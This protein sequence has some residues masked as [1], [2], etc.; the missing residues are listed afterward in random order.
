MG[1]GLRRAT[2]ATLKTRSWTVEGEPL[3]GAE[4]VAAYEALPDTGAFLRALGCSHMSSR[5][6]DRTLALLKKAGLI[7]YRRPGGW[8]KLGEEENDRQISLTGD[9]NDNNG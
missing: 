9:G 1:R 5:L 7:E 8:T 6:A 4:V 2:L 3:M